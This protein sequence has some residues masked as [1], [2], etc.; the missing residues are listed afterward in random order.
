MT[1]QGEH[2]CII[3]DLAISLILP[4][5]PSVLLKHKPREITQN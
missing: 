3:F 2:T 4:P 5:D 1:R